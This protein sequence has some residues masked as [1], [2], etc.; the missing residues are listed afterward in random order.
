M[1]TQESSPSKPTIDNSGHSPQSEEDEESKGLKLVLPEQ[2]DNVEDKRHDDNNGIQDFKLVVEE[3]PAV[4][5]EF[6]GHLHQK[7]SQDGKAQVVEDLEGTQQKC[8]W[9]WDYT[10]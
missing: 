10:Q 7:E 6:K 9:D 1:S 2:E 8:L 3:F 4:D 5:K